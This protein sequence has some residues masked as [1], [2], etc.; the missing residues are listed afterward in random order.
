MYAVYAKRPGPE[1][2][3]QRDKGSFGLE[4]NF[5][6]PGSGRRRDERRG[7]QRSGGPGTKQALWRGGR[8][9]DAAH[10]V[11]V[12]RENEQLELEALEVRKHLGNLRQ[13]LRLTASSSLHAPQTGRDRSERLASRNVLVALARVLPQGRSS[14]AESPERGGACDPLQT[15]S[16]RTQV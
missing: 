12:R 15:L 11:F 10:Y 16:S 2:T 13:G 3:G 4:K 9:G 5:G 1:K 7:A 8:G 6:S 14:L